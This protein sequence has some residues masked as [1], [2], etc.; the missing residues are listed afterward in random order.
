[1]KNRVKNNFL[2]GVALL[3]IQFIFSQSVTLSGKVVDQQTNIPLEYCTVSV[4]DSNTG[5]LVEGSITKTDGTFAIELAKGTYTVLI[6]YISFESKKITP[7]KINNDLDL[8]TVLL[9]IDTQQ[10]ENVTIV[11]EKTEV[12][13]RLDKR[14]YN[15]GKDLTI[16]GGT[17]SDV[18]DN[19]PSVSVD[20]EGNVALRGNQNVRILINGKP[21]SL[22]GLS[23]GDALRQL[24]A[25]TI[26]KVEVITS[27]SARYEAEGSAGIIN[28][29]LVRNKFGGFNG[30]LSS[31]I[32]YPK[33][34]GLSGNINY[35]TNTYNL[36]LNSGYSNSNSLGNS[37]Y[38][39]EFINPEGNDA[40]IENRIFDRNRIGWNTN[41][42][43]EYF[44][45]KKSSLTT[46]L[47]LNDRDNN[48]VATNQLFSTDYGKTTVETQRQEKEKEV[49]NT[50]EFNLNFN[51]NFN[52]EGHVLSFDFQKEHSEEVEDGDVFINEIAPNPSQ[53]LGE[54]VLTE[55]SFDQILI[56]ADYVNPFSE[57]GQFEAGFRSAQKDIGLLYELTNEN[58]T[59]EFEV[60]LNNTL[61][62]QENI[63]A[64]Y[65]QYG[66]KHGKFSYFL[67]LRFE[68]S[69]ITINQKMLETTKKN[70]YSDWFPTLNLSY[71]L[72]DNES[73]TLGFNRRISRPRGRFINPFP[74][75]SSA[76]NLFQGNPDIQPSYSNGVDLGYLKRFEQI[77][78]NGSIYFRRQTDV[79]TFIL[80]DTGDQTLVG[81][82]LVPILRRYPINLASQNRYGFE[83]NSS[84]SF[85]KKWRVN[86]NIN[87]F[88]NNLKGRHNGKI[89]DKKSASWSGRLSN[90]LTLP[91]KIDWQTNVYYRGPSENAESKSKGFASVSTAISKDVLKDNG[92]LTFRVSD[93]FNSQRRR[94]NLLT[95]TI[96]NYS[97]F[98][99][100]EPSYTLS[101][102]Y[103][104][105]ERKSRRPS[106]GQGSNQ[107]ESFDF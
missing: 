99:W 105:N 62:Y 66:N 50:I 76:T 3:S 65:T 75:R 20:I 60:A 4:L 61:E 87:F 79:F 45:T 33:S 13:I 77:T 7:V 67:G 19:V 59:G 37:Y 38:K 97:E 70:S 49:D 11:R 106:R 56:Q 74:S 55:E 102:T 26:D 48:N 104:F 34:F 89:Y 95:E 84:A 24:P 2:I 40:L 54:T 83:L 6:D 92:T 91:K 18:L 57:N 98:Q 21:S 25:E 94:S 86:G 10:L 85:S 64:V 46:S 30:S 31:N 80:E 12:E 88:A 29:I 81:G 32:A 41:L 52:E 42:G 51:H 8:G 107:G 78:L 22:V 39:S 93:V 63:H 69:E 58:D 15:V 14:V 27:P 82:T 36:F 17:V 73:I 103:R 71:E 68:Q 100:R 101:F 35:R 96:K 23:G 43:I 9:E 1:M 16:R 47:F 5:Q 72:N 28:I 90:T 44:I 53:K